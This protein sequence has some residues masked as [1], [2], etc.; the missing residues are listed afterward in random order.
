MRPD[1]SILKIIAGDAWIS[2]SD[3][4][5]NLGGAM[6]FGRK[7][8]LG[9]IQI[10][11]PTILCGL[12][13]EWSGGNPTTSAHSVARIKTERQRFLDSTLIETIGDFA[14]SRRR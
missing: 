7:N 13:I 10:E 5:R 3:Q 2:T 1:K 4:M 8:G 11:E 9:E 12:C 6:H 14:Q